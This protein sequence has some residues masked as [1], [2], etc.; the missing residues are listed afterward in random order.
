MAN[1]IA[2]ISKYIPLLDKK[3]QTVSKTAFLD[4]RSSLVRETEDAKSILLPKMTLSGLADYSRNGGYVAGDENLTWQTHTF[5]QDRGRMFNIDTMDNIETALI[6]YGQ[7]A[8]EFIRLHVV[9]ELDA[10]RI[11]KYATLA[12]TKA[13]GA[14]DETNIL[15][16]LVKARTTLVN[17]HVGLEDM[18]LLVTP[19]TY[20][21]MMMDEK[22]TKN[23]GVD[24]VSAGNVNIEVSTWNRIPIMEVP[25]DR[26]NTAFTL[27]DGTSSG[28]TDGGFTPS[29]DPVNFLL[30]AR[31]SVLQITKRAAPKVVTPAE[32]QTADG[33][34]FGYRIYHDAFVPD[35][36]ADGIYAHTNP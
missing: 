9:P 16:E 24:K 28:Q 7:L 27:L 1:N 6:A 34:K 14:I 3:Y 11:S 18:A 20:G 25:A 35:N 19:D 21:S 31:S 29:G 8:G 4:L 12:G 17:K 23:I 13:T 36:K 32:N 33:W 15:S 10:Y 22:I 26:M 30:L 2:L 5:T